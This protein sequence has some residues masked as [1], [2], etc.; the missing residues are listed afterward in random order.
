MSSGSSKGVY[1]FF[2]L[3]LSLED[4]SIAALSWFFYA[5]FLSSPL[6]CLYLCETIKESD[7]K[8]DKRAAMMRRLQFETRYVVSVPP[9]EYALES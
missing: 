4:G 1:S 8:I 2:P 7:Q 5:L 3:A 9:F 6:V